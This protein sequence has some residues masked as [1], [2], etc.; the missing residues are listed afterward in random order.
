MKDNCRCRRFLLLCFRFLGNLFLFNW[1]LSDLRLDRFIFL[2]FLFLRFLYLLSNFNFFFKH[3][4]IFFIIL[5][6]RFCG[7][8][9]IYN[10]HWKNLTILPKRFQTLWWFINCCIFGWFNLDIHNLI[11][12]SQRLQFLRSKLLS[13]FCGFLH[14]IF[15]IFNLSSSKLIKMWRLTLQ[16]LR[17]FF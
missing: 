5:T 14:C 7:L 9:I 6:V 12:L 10:L 2:G 16:H 8:L 1:L 15:D 3:H 4:F 11:V 13:L 17:I